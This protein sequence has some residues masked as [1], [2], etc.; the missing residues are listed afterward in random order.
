MNKNRTAT[1]SDVEKIVSKAV[2]EVTETIIDGV[3]GMFHK[4]NKKF[5]NRFN[6]LESDVSHVKNNINNL[7]AD[8]ST[9]PTRKEFSDLKSRVDTYH[10]IS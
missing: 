8:I 3:E 2:T 6:Q 5:D 1:I 4:Q 7:K 9:T 10:P